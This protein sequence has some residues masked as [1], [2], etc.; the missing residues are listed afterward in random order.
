MEQVLLAHKDHRVQLD[1]Q[2]H[3]EPLVELVIL[4]HRVHRVIL[5]LQAHKD[6]LVA[7]VQREHRAIQVQRDQRGRILR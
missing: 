7:L 3:R 1:R 6:R 2:A 5:V 4:V